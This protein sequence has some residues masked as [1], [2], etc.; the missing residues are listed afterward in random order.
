LTNIFY[1]LNAKNMNILQDKVAI[2]TGGGQGIGAGIAKVLAKAGAKVM[3]SDLNED[4]AR[5]VSDQIIADGGQAISSACDVSNASQVEEM[6]SQ[7]VQAYQKV[8]IL[9][10]NAGIF[11]FKS[12][13]EMSVEDFEKVM[14]VNVKGVFL[15]TKEALKVMPEGGRVVTISSI[16]SIVG[17]EGL[18]HY[19]G[20]KGAVNSW[21]RALAIELSS[22][23]ITVNAVAPGAIETPGATGAMT[24]EMKQGF[25]ASIPL[26]R[27]GK[28]ED[29]ANAVKFLASDEAGYIT[30][31]TIVVDGGWTLK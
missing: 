18:T 10:N 22:R 24:D 25:I 8:D 7:T 28:P 11:P 26:K 14:D 1:K 20:S 12:F 19:C 9:V 30:G 2:V 4:K 21:T 5:Q 17:F 27:M 29:I 3:V 6:V 15:C 13:V 23:Q 31:Q 16:A